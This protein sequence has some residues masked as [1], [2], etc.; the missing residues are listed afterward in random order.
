MDEQRKR[1]EECLAHYEELQENLRSL[2]VSYL[3]LKIEYERLEREA[4]N[5]LLSYRNMLNLCP[6]CGGETQY[7]ML[8]GSKY[9]VRGCR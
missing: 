2:S 1:A 8:D 3:P 9:C 4:A 6:Q 5:A 7:E